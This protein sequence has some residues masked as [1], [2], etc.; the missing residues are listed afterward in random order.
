MLLFMIHK[1]RS[2][3]G[4][5]VETTNVKVTSEHIEHNIVTR[6]EEFAAVTVP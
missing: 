3:L 1:N 2:T 6:K 4:F 5:S